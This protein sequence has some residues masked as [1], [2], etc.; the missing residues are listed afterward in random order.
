MRYGVDGKA[1][2]R[3]AR[4]GAIGRDHL[5]DLGHQFGRTT[6]FATTALERRPGSLWSVTVNTSRRHE[7]IGSMRTSASQKASG[8]AKGS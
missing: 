3:G 1:S 8:A 4:L 7:P 6:S 2:E 5:G